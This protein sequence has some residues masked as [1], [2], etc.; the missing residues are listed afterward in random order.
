MKTRTKIRV[1]AILLLSVV[2]AIGLTQFFMTQELNE[3]QQKENAVHKITQGVF[4]LNILESDY[5]LHQQERAMVQWHLK[6]DSLSE[7]LGGLEFGDPREQAILEEIRQ[8]HE[9]IHISFDRLCATYEDGGGNGGESGL[10]EMLAA[11]LSVK[12]T[13]MVSDASLLEEATEDRLMAA[14]QTSS[15]FVLIFEVIIAGGIV[16]IS[17]TF[18][19]MTQE[20]RETQEQLREA[21]RLTII[22]E[23]AAMVGHDLRNPLQAMMGLRHI[24]REE[25]GSLPSKTPQRK[26]LEELDEMVGEQIV[27]MDKVVSDLQSYTRSM[28][29]K[30][31]P[32]SLQRLIEGALHVVAV[33]ENIR[34]SVAIPG[35][36]PRIMADAE[37]MKRVFANLMLNAVQA[38]PDGGKL[39][40][41]AHDTDGAA[42]MSVEDTGVGIPEGDLPRLFDPLFTTKAK[43]QGLGLAVCKKIVEAHNGTISVES[44]MGKGSKFTVEIPSNE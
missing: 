13:S 34:V 8:N 1:S 7:Q 35:D 20:L 29:S 10:R 14:M 9:E 27:Y 36:L 19:R 40:I 18:D 31:T 6:H 33:P 44:E 3:A 4:Q 42:S 16:A 38:M 28:K 23:T 32:T 26:T 12:S 43:G 17:W 41:E 2:A 25:V 22:G 39:T 5:Q 15:S 30:P 11:Q 24:L 37:M 21:E